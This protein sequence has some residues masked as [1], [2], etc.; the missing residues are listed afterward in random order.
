MRLQLKHKKNIAKNSGNMSRQSI[1][2][3]METKQSI[4]ACINECYSSVRTSEFCR[5][6]TDLGS[7]KELC[8][9]I[10]IRKQSIKNKNAIKYLAYAIC[11]DCMICCR[12]NQ[13]ST[14]V[15][16]WASFYKTSILLLSSSLSSPPQA[17]TK[18][19]TK[20]SKTHVVQNLS[21]HA[22]SMIQRASVELSESSTVRVQKNFATSCFN[23][24]FTV[25]AGRLS[26]IHSKNS[27]S[28]YLQDRDEFFLS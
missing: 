3:S 6:S 9:V 12:N 11:V 17:A 2:I 1:I 19:E 14:C 20:Q 8:A 23:D 28:S 15:Y 5:R 21:M 27:G 13:S 4:S 10:I 16:R 7:V 24:M 22:V 18:A 25:R 26:H